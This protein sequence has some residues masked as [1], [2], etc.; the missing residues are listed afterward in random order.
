MAKSHFVVEAGRLVGPGGP[1]TWL[2]LGMRTCRVTATVQSPGW[3]VAVT[4][5]TT[6]GYANLEAGSTAR[7][8][9]VLR[10]TGADGVARAS[11][12]GR[13]P[14]TGDYQTAGEM[15]T[16]Y[17]PCGVEPVLTVVERAMITAGESPERASIL[18]ADDLIADLRR[19]SALP[20]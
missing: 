18:T 13:G 16:G 12:R 6:V 9:G 1:P 4:T 17:A 3:T 19:R 11:W 10:L 20:L 15:S 8:Q 2:P 5:P 14:F 7:Y